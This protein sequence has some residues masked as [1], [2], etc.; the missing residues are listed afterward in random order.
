MRDKI[1]RFLVML[2]CGEYWHDYYFLFGCWLIGGESQ[3]TEQNA[4]VT[5]RRIFPMNNIWVR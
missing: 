5:N 4:V 2:Q 3:P 1:K